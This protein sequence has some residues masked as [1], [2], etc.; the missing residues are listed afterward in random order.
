MG[1]SLWHYD[2]S[3]LNYLFNSSKW[4]KQESSNVFLEPE[5]PKSIVRNLQKIIPVPS[6]KLTLLCY[7]ICV[8]NTCMYSDIEQNRNML[9]KP[10]R[11]TFRRQYI[12]IHYIPRTY[13]HMEIKRVC[14][15]LAAGGSVAELLKV[16]EVCACMYR[17]RQIWRW[18]FGGDAA[19]Q[20]TSAPPFPNNRVWC[21]ADPILP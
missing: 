1:S 14:V 6:F 5:L 2:A 3:Y 13:I 17:R 8:I 7:H 18:S 9:W 11:Q 21:P 16:C 19:T 15:K 10:S 20:P 12:Y 4:W